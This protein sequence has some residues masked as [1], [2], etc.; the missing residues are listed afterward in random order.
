MVRYVLAGCAVYVIAGSAVSLA[1]FTSDFATSDECMFCHTSGG[2]ALRDNEGNSLSIADD[3]SSSMMGNSF[4]DPFFRAKLESEVVRNP[5]LAAA[6]EDKCLTCHAPMARTQAVKDG[7]GS[8]SLAEAETTMFAS[9]GVSCALC[10]QIQKDGLGEES[11]FS[12]G[13]VISG[14][15]KMF[16][17][18][19]QVFAN[20]MINHVDYLPTFGEQVDKPG[21]CATCHT[22]F[23]PIVAEDGQIIGEFPEQTPYLEWL[24][25]AYAAPENYRSCQDCHMPRIDEPVKISNRPPWYQ[26][27]QS[28][29][30]KHHFTGGN[31]F[32]LE[33]LKN[34]RQRLGIPVPEALFE[35]TIERTEGRLGQEAAEIS[36]VR[37][38]RNNHRLLVD[39]R[40]ANNT[41]HKFPTG[42]PSRRAWLHLEATDDQKRTIFE[43]GGVTPEG[44]IVGLDSDYEPH[45][46]VIDSADQVQIYQS[47]MGD[48]SGGMTSTLL[49]AA[50]YLKD[51]RLP[52]RGYQRSG[53]M[54]SQT[55]TKG[56]A[57]NDMNFNVGDNGEG[58]GT[59]IVTFDIDLNNARYPLTIKAELLY[60]SSSPWFLNDL[61]GD[62]TPAVARF[63]GMFAEGDNRPVVVDTIAYE[64]S[65]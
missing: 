46:T 19:K 1:S 20:P 21:F 18:Y 17:P 28:P 56:K 52:P 6:I 11:S 58:S 34:N 64:L 29:F 23:T 39:V 50:T 63:K 2:S 7:A 14:E 38:E 32:I 26:Q 15:R 43:S 65:D 22:L 13:Y 37:V 45:H 10:H 41:G 35:R 51:N 24:N 12:G 54:S 40:V 62:D 55:G 59:D 53:P 42:F 8:Y 27:T 3:W 30:W 16:G 4:R 47:I 36:I 49:R 33:M 61:F 57:I 60:Q 5:Q 9:D 31:V 25:S 44:E 48:E